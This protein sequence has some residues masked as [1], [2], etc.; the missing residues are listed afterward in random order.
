MVNEVGMICKEG[1]GNALG[2][3]YKNVGGFFGLSAQLRCFIG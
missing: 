1:T 3:Y 2:K